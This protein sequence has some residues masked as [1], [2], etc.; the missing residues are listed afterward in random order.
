MAVQTKSLTYR[1]VLAALF[2][3]LG[4]VMPFLTGQIPQLGSALLPM[5]L[6]VLLCGFV[7]GWKYGLAVGAI[8]PLFRSICFGA[9][10]MYPAAVAMMLDRKSVV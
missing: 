2:I 1:L 9:P 8:V 6:P 5:H 4:L 10:P 3:A 7:L